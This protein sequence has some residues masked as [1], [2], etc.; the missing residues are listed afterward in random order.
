LSLHFDNLADLDLAIRCHKSPALYKSWRAVYFV[1]MFVR[2]DGAGETVLIV[3][4]VHD[5]G[6]VLAPQLG[7]FLDQDWPRW[8]LLVGDD[9]ASADDLATLALFRQRASLR[10]HQVKV[11]RGPRKGFACNYLTL[12]RHLPP[13]TGCVALSD[14]DDIWLPGKLTRAIDALSGAEGP[15]I[16]CG[17]RWIWDPARNLRYPARALRHAPAFHNALVENIASGNTIVLNPAALELVRRSPPEADHVFAHDWWIYLLVTG[18]GGQVI[19]DPLPQILYRQHDRNVLG[20]GER[21]WIRFTTGF[22]VLTGAYRDRV[23]RNVQALE[24]ACHLLTPQN[25]Q[26]LRRVLEAQRMVWPFRGWRMARLGLYRQGTLAQVGFW[27][28]L[29]FA[30]L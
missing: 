6:A 11:V 22:S 16:Y 18:A 5:A 3:M 8:D 2:L 19:H 29:A 1:T 23:V 12:L 25:Q 26:L 17:S 4:G 7:S 9:G 27:G 15:A 14:Q 13:E 20:A 21:G 10:G 30:R 24:A 28:A